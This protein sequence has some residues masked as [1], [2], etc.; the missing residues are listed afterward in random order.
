MFA[1]SSAAAIVDAIG[2]ANVNPEAMAT[3]P[4]ETQK[5]AFVDRISTTLFLQTPMKPELR[6]KLVEE[7]ELIKSGF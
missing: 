7:F 1:P 4:E 2:Y 3:I 6:D 5:A